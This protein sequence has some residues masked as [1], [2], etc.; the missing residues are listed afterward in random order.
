MEILMSMLRGDL[1]WMKH[2][3]ISGCVHYLT[4]ELAV[5]WKRPRTLDWQPYSA[6][7]KRSRLQHQQNQ[8]HIHRREST[9]VARAA[10][11]AFLQAVV[12]LR[13]RSGRMQ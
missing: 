5:V 8:L 9:A 11:P 4:R 13:P 3:S 1:D 12:L 7:I 10:P 6:D 2:L